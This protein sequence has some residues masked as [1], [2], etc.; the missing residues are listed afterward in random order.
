MRLGNGFKGGK[1]WYSLEERLCV[2][3]KE[4]EDS[5]EHVLFRCN[6]LA[7]IRRRY[8]LGICHDWYNIILENRIN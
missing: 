4:E 7:D 6:V 8:Q 1:D 5:L 3:C 2:S